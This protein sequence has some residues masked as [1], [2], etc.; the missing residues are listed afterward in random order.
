MMNDER[1]PIATGHLSDYGDQIKI[2][3]DQGMLHYNSLEQ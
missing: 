1:Q 3:N 2:N